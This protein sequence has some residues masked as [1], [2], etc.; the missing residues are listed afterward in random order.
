MYDLFMEKK[1]ESFVKAARALLKTIGVVMY[2]EAMRG[3]IETVR[4]HDYRE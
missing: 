3:L 4:V 2:F 1:S